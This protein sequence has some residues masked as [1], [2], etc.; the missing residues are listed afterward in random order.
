M[1]LAVTPSGD[2]YVIERTG[3][4][5]LVD[6]KT[7]RVRDALVI[8][9]DT[10]HENGLL[11]IAL[12]P[13]FE[14]D[15]R[16]Y[17]YYSEPVSE[18]LP[19]VGPPARN[20]L[21]RFRALADG[22]L[23]P[24]SREEIVSVP[25]ERRCCHEGG[26]LAFLPDGT[27]LLST[28][29]NTDPF[30]ASGVAPLDGRPGRETFDARRSASNPADLRGKILRLAPDG[31]IPPGNL[32]PPDGT[33]G[34]PEIYAM[35]VR[36]PFRLAADALS[37]RLFFGDI[38]PDARNDTLLGPRGYDEINIAD[39]PA[40]FGWPFCIGENL[41]YNDRDF[42]TGLVGEPFDCAEKKPPVIAY[43]YETESVPALGTALDAEGVF[44]GSA[45]MAGAVYR[46]RADARWVFPES[47]DG[48]L[49]MADWARD[50]LATVHVNEAG[51]LVGVER[52]LETETFRRPID[53]DVGPDG[54]LYVLEFGSG[55]FGDNEDAALSRIEYAAHGELSPVA[56]IAASTKYGSAPLEVAFSGAESRAFGKSERIVDYLW[57]FDLDGSPDAS[58]RDIVRRFESTGSF[59]V[60]LSV[61][62]SS[63][64]R[65]RPVSETI[66]VG[67]APP[68]VEIL[69]PNPLWVAV[70]GGS[71]PLRGEATDPE[72]GRASCDELVW[73]LGLGHNAH[74]HP[75][76]TLVG[77]DQSFVPE[78]MDH[79]A[80]HDDL[81]FLTIELVYT[82]H[83]GRN[84]EPALT[85]RQGLR[86]DLAVP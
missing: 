43:D 37:G 59:A 67:N 75:V 46:T 5:R 41:A 9:V 38:G 56:S 21:A 7:G 82:D 11:G 73:N 71:L 30:Q 19:E 85:G 8:D 44:V 51:E 6:A 47:F 61:I 55:F 77:C 34:R 4:L 13:A 1:A 20:V 62:S 15:P 58:G 3:E 16:V 28:G 50:R 69:E 70:P 76:S 78:V 27:L 39:G 40:D 66:V 12:E 31:G 32:F 22:S 52:F 49:I 35:G 63:G 81:I 48:A 80:S 72:D 14:D 53:V 25:S 57:D 24:E 10:R 17:L 84:G 36:N 29:D 83:G 18:P 33:L 26:S 79:G 23:D 2:V 54:A 64:A 68:S 65:S 74:S 45:V 60:G 86:V 42:A